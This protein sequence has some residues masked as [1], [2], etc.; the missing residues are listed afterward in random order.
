MGKPQTQ[1]D[2]R[3]GRP[4]TLFMVNSIAEQDNKTLDEPA[5]HSTSE[6]VSTNA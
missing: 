6:I 5:Q 2:L 1:T 4:T 3:S